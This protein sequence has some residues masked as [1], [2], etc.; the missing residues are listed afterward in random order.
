MKKLIYAALILSLSVSA[1]ESDYEEFIK[2]DSVIYEKI[3]G[4]ARAS[5]SLV[6][7]IINLST[8]KDYAQ[9]VMDSYQGWDLQPVLDLR[10][11][12]FKFVDNAPCSGLLT[13]FDGRSYILFKACG[14]VSSEELMQLYK[15]ANE[16]LKLDETLKKQSKANLY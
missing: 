9:Y 1:K 6:N 4:S 2:S 5:L 3:D 13:Y 16:K 7:P 14:V 12:S 10:G 15:R 8:T 11:F